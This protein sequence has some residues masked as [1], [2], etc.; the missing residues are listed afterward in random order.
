RQCDED[1]VCAKGVSQV[2]QQTPTATRPV[3]TATQ[4]VMASR[5]GTTQAEPAGQ[6]PPPERRQLSEAEASRLLPDLRQRRG[7]DVRGRD[8]AQPIAGDQLVAQA[9]GPSSAGPQ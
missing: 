2:A 8:Q 5:R 7:W 1:F 4:A 3:L 9:R 6:H